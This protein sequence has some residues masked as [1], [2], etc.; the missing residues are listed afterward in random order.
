MNTKSK[1][2]T[3]TLDNLILDKDNPR[4]AE[5]YSGSEKEDEIIEYLLYTELAEEVAKAIS[6]ADEYYPDR[7]L[8]VL[9]EGDKYLVKDGNRRC[10]AVKALKHPIKYGLELKK[11]ELNNLPVLVYNN[12]SDLENRIRQE[13]TSNLFRQWSRI[14]KALEV[15]R[16]YASGSSLDSMI[17]YDS[18]PIDLIRLASFYYES[19]KICSEDFKKLLRSGKG[20]SGGK[21]IIFERLF[22]FRNVCGYTFKNKSTNEILIKDYKLFTSYII[23]MVR[24]LPE[25]PEVTS[26]TI[27]DEQDK[28]LDRLKPYGFPSIN[29]L[30]PNESKE[31]T[32]SS[33]DKK[34]SANQ[35]AS[36]NNNNSNENNVQC[37]TPD[38]NTNEDTIGNNSTNSTDSNQ[39]GRKSVK[40]KP[41]YNRKKIPAPLERLIK[42]CY[43]LDQNNFANAKTAL[44][45][46]TFECTLK[47]VIENTF[48]KNGKSLA[49]LN[50]FRFAYYNSKGEKLLYT[51]FEYLKTRFSELIINTGIRKAFENFDLQ[52]LHQIIHNYHVG[53]IPA[54]AKYICDNLIVLLEFMLQEE[55][56]LLSSIDTS[57]F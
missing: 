32:E 57:K 50:Y 44:T 53:A 5:L 54:D 47:Y 20:K 37:K 24:F 42:E 31:G 15:H 19:V 18:S 34:D 55:N 36:Q 12:K 46:V 33:F 9:K 10:A 17:E 30:V 28:F 39:N 21:T 43:D 25:H 3:V 7:P 2:L 22:K 51:N 40:H 45:R 13:H 27:D 29:D 1:Q 11:I 48:Q 56:E 6:I 14:A 4:F 49:K 38:D 52:R 26:R 35:Y 41:S 16:L 23:A 8:W